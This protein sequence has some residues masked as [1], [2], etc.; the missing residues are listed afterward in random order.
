MAIKSFQEGEKPMIMSMLTMKPI[1]PSINLVGLKEFASEVIRV[2]GEHG[3]S[4][5]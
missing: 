2:E 3:H 5:S 1:K 4:T